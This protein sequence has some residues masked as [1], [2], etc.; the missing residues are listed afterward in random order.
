MCL[1]PCRYRGSFTTNLSEYNKKSGSKKVKY[2]N[3]HLTVLIKYQSSQFFPMTG[4]VLASKG[5][6]MCMKLTETLQKCP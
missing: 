1:Q 2:P 4:K 3:V 5:E 6:K